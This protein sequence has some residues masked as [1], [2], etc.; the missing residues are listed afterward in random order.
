[1]AINS[2]DLRLVSKKI[3]QN[4]SIDFYSEHQ[5]DSIL[6]NSDS[7][8]QKILA[9][10]IHRDNIKAIDI[11]TLITPI[12]E[13]LNLSDEFIKNWGRE[14]QN[15]RNQIEIERKRNRL[16]E[17]K[18]RTNDGIV[19]LSD[20]IGLFAVIDYNCRKIILGKEITY[21]NLNNL[22]NLTTVAF[23]SDVQAKKLINEANN[24]TQTILKNVKKTVKYRLSDKQKMTKVKINSP[25][26]VDDVNSIS[27]KLLHIY[28]PDKNQNSDI[29]IK[30]FDQMA[31][32]IL[33]YRTSNNLV[34]LCDME[35]NHTKILNRFY[36]QRQ[37]KTPKSK[38]KDL[39]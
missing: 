18:K 13:I 10:I 9:C 15:I 34:A 21:I 28:H 2:L 31:S 37:S 16:N 1:M 32:M 5:R 7:F 39:Q 27:K 17:L 24:I 3:R 4:L 19:D 8:T 36:E 29:D 23:Y 14:Q 11:Q 30:V 35:K 20:I 38:L 33:E 6:S 22:P 26:S 12:D 25:V